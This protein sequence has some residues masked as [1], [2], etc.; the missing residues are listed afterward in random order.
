MR[1]RDGQRVMLTLELR[2]SA[3][4]CDELGKWVLD[5]EQK[6]DTLTRNSPLITMVRP[7]KEARSVATVPS[8]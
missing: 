1:P 5:R 2:V 7:K 3:F 8:P 6:L 4:W